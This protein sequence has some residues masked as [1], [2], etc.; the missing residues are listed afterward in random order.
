[1]ATTPT[2][3]SSPVTPDTFG[4]GAVRSSTDRKVRAEPSLPLATLAGKVAIVTGAS[5]GIGAAI[6]TRLA[7][8]GAKVIV[9]YFSS[10]KSAD[11]VVAVIRAGGG[12]A[13][14]VQADAST[15]TGVDKLFSEAKRLFG[16]VDI[17][18]SN[19]GAVSI[20]PVASITEDDYQLIFNTNVKGPAFLLR[21]AANMVEE[22]GRI[23][24]IGSTAHRGQPS[25]GLYAASK[26]A[27]GAFSAALAI[28]LAPKKITVNTVH[29]GYTLTDMMY[30]NVPE[31]AFPAL[32]DS[33]MPSKRFGT[34]AD[35]GDA[36]ALF[37]SEG[38]RWITGQQVMVAGGFKD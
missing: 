25:M 21:N 37:A 6:C 3:T 14:A 13:E 28:E 24:S 5:R 2:P 4:S 8:D 20:K 10:P 17:V 29:P 36:V 22:G 32:L 7:S 35:I 34:P 19:A 38:A 30:E 15:I 23:I 16:R 1:M 9:N 12:V 31:S 18:V 27:L 11:E 33:L 26:A